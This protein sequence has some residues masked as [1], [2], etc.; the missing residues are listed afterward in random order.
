MEA[1]RREIKADGQD[2]VHLSLTLID[3]KMGCKYKSDNRHIKVHVSG[4]GRLVALDSGELRAENTFF[5]DNVQSYFGRALVTVQST[6]K[7]GTIRVEIEV[8]GLEK[9]YVQ[10]ILTRSV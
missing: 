7:P 4:E 6:R 3:D 5:K 1:D 8:E 10:E 9:K 2:L